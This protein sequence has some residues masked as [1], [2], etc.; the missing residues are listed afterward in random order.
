MNKVKIFVNE[1]IYTLQRLETYRAVAEDAAQK[2]RHNNEVQKETL[3]LRAALDEM[4]D[5]IETMQLYLDEIEVK[6]DLVDDTGKRKD[7]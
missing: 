1:L 6:A 7:E 2:V 4:A 3:R 5:T